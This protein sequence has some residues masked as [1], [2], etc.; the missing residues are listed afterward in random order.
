MGGRCIF[1][2]RIRPSSVWWCPSRGES[3]WLRRRGRGEC[4]GG[5][6][7]NEGECRTSNIQRSTSKGVLAAARGRTLC[8]NFA[9][10]M[11]PLR[12]SV[13]GHTG[14]AGT[15]SS[16][17]FKGSGEMRQEW[18]QRLRWMGATVL[19]LAA[20]WVQPSHGGILYAWGANGY[21]QLGDGTTAR[22]VVP[23][24]VSISGGIGAAAAGYDFSLAAQNGAVYSWE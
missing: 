5:G 8:K 18:K 21:G 1:S 4:G 7:S 14:F 6:G 17:S 15:R 2:Q 9:C 16:F 10:S 3:R 22:H 12:G 13:L 24:P 11:R 23:G 20:V 19:G